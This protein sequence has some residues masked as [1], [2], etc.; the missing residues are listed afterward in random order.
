M[1]NKL[2]SVPTIDC[3][4]FI[5]RE[6]RYEDYNDLYEYGKDEETVKYVIWGPYA[7][8]D[9]AIWSLENK[10][11]NRLE[12]GLPNGFAIVWKENNKMIGTCDT[13]VWYEDTNYVEI[14]YIINKDYWGRGIV[15]KACNEV[16]K[17]SFNV[18]KVDG[19]TICHL[20]ENIGSKRVRKDL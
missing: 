3:G 13:P 19:I 15:T 9:D 16:I 7:K 1:K 20:P 12:N 10:F 17:Y 11:L 8:I 6:F 14:G 5:L 18:L 4:D 2:E